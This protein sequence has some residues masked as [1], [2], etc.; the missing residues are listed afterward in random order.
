MK[1]KPSRAIRRQRQGK[2]PRSMF[3]AETESTKRPY[4]T[5]NRPRRTT[6]ASGHRGLYDS[7]EWRARRAAWLEAH[8]YCVKHAIC[9]NPATVADHIVR[10]TDPDSREQVLDGEIQSMCKDCHRQK[11]ADD[12]AI[13]AGRKPKKIARKIEID[14][15]T[16][17]PLPGQPWHPWSEVE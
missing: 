4:D 8:P 17:Y 13:M 2:A 14:P 10:V 7:A 3:M 5:T 11:S 16:G 1:T 15:K 6:K 9:G 12:R